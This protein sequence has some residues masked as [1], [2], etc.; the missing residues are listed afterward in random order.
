MSLYPY[1][2]ASYRSTAH[3]DFEPPP[4]WKPRARG[5]APFFLFAASCGY[6]S[7]RVVSCAW[8]CFSY[9][10]GVVGHVRLCFR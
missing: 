2:E 9:L 1:R 3:V 8:G 4:W 5:A 7:V 10:V 6:L